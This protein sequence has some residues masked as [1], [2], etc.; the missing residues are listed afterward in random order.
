MRILTYFLLFYSLTSLAKPSIFVNKSQQNLE[1]SILIKRVSDRKTLFET[2]PDKA[3]TPASLAKLFCA[4]SFLKNFGKMKNLKT[5][6]YHSGKKSKGSVKGDLIIKGGGD[7]KLVTEDLWKIVHDMKHL[8]YKEFSGDLVLDNSLFSRE[9]LNKNRIKK[10]SQNSYDA[11]VSALGVNFNTYNI[12]VSPGK[13]AGS[14]AHVS[15]YPYPIRGTEVKNYVKTVSSKKRNYISI[16]RE[17]RKGKE[18]II[19]RGRIYKDSPLRKFY[20]SSYDP[21]RFSGE[22]IRSFLKAQNIIV[23]GKVK[24]GNLSSYKSSTKILSYKSKPIGELTKDFLLYSNNYMTDMLVSTLGAHHKNK[25]TKENLYN[26][27]LNII[28]N[29]LPNK[30]LTKKSSFIFTSGSG[31]KTENK[32]SSHHVVDL[33][34]MMSKNFEVFPEF[35]NALPKAGMNGS[36]KKRFKKARMKPLLGKVRAKTGTLTQP[37]SV[38]SLAGYMYHK[39]HGL[40]AFS[41]IQNG[42]FGKKQP[43]ILVMRQAQEL[44]LI[45]IL[46]KL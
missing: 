38:S 7:P 11:P 37:V 36:L 2:N 30:A 27:G 14:K 32:I 22:T 19:A 13:R 39:K 41:I 10:Y 40:L 6:F 29:I 45:K 43:N 5:V 33:L 44:G 1:Q 46:K 24:E 15:L 28:K 17:L 42:F 35:L 34:I 8:G 9:K 31:L 18:V 16:R 3:L 20:R 21:V 4:A 23:K 12:V 25:E 26:N